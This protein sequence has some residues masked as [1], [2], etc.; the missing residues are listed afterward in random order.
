MDGRHL[1]YNLIYGAYLTMK[2]PFSPYLASVKPLLKTLI[3]KLNEEYP[4][5][6]ILA[7]DSVA[8]RIGV[9]KTGVNV[10]EVGTLTKR[11][12]V[13]RIHNGR[14]FSEYA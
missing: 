14:G 13:A 12:F 3:E 1:T 5:A 8:Q 6:S 9:S 10:S 2:L 4:Y 7:Q 11:G